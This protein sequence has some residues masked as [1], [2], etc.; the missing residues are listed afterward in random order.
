VGCLLLMNTIFPI[1]PA[2]DV[3]IKERLNEVRQS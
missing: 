3:A 2:F 1:K